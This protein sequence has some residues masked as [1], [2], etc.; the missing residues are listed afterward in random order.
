MG[1]TYL[2]QTALIALGRKARHA[3]FRARLDAKLSSSLTVVLSSWHLV[4]TAHT[5]KLANAIELATFIDSLKPVWLHEL[6][7]LRKMDIEDD[8]YK[9]LKVEVPSQVRVTTK[10]AV[11]AELHRSHDGPRFDI[12]SVDFVRQWV[13]NP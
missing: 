11:F 5:K 10:S 12:P 2:D 13:Q 3:E 6:F 1:L 9:F 4:E 8:F 7:T